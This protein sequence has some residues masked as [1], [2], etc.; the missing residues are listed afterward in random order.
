MLWHHL[1]FRRLDG[2]PG[3][4]GTA[5]FRINGLALK[6]NSGSENVYNEF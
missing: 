4:K 2:F 3:M 1:H 6:S 5:R